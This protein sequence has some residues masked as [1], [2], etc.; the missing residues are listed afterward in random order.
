M[1][2]SDSKNLENSENCLI[3][4]RLINPIILCSQSI[5]S[6]RE[7][8]K[9]SLKELSS[10]T[11]S[12]EKLIK[13][14]DKFCQDPGKLA[15]PGVLQLTSILEYS[16]GSVYKTATRQSPPHL[17]KDVIAELT[18]ISCFEFNQVK[19][20]LLPSKGLTPTSF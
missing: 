17:L 18:K 20:F 8:F 6:N 11:F 16:L 4:K 5:L 7:T 12:E 13:L 9:L 19:I 2:I 1:K 3:L 10:W 14:F 15:L